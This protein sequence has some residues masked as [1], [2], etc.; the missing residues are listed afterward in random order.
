M[1]ATTAMT[2]APPDSQRRHGRAIAGLASGRSCPEVSLIIAEA[3]GATG[4]PR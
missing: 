2:I 1:P 3:G 4:V